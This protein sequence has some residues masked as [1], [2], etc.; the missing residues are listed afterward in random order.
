MTTFAE[1]QVQF[2]GNTYTVELNNDDNHEVMVH[3]RRRGSDD[4]YFSTIKP[5][6]QNWNRAVRLAYQA[7]GL[8][9]S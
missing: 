5:K 1:Q 9:R 8:L 3:K 6:S 2:N 7:A 4:C